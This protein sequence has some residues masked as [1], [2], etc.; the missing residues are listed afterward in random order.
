M[1]DNPRNVALAYAVE[2]HGKTQ[3][4]EATAVSSSEHAGPGVT[5]TGGGAGVPAEGGS[6]G[7]GAATPSAIRSSTGT[8]VMVIE[9]PND[10]AEVV[11]A[12]EAYAAFL[13]PQ[14]TAG[15]PIAAQV[16]AVYQA[17]KAAGFYQWRSLIDFGALVID[18][19][20]V[21]DGGIEEGSGAAKQLAVVDE[22]LKLV[23]ELLVS[24]SD[25][26]PF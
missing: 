6:G 12:A 25:E 8:A 11:A 24:R 21:K 4:P 3:R 9:V 14:A 5:V 13:D 19:T 26:E 22:L 16:E 7:G 15:D 20:P 2:S 10:P 23:H 18:G 17:A 1:A